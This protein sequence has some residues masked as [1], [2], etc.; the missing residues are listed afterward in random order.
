MRER[1]DKLD[2]IRGEDDKVVLVME[3][4]LVEIHK[5]VRGMFH[6]WVDLEVHHGVEKVLD[7]AG[8]GFRWPGAGHAEGRVFEGSQ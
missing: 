2:V 6:A 4:V 1:S 5:V 8:L 3:V 7:G